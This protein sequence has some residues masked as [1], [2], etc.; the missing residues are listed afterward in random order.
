M[1]NCKYEICEERRYSEGDVFYMSYGIRYVDPCGNII[2]QVSDIS[3]DSIFTEKLCKLLND[4][5]VSVIH[6]TDIIAD[7]I[8]EIF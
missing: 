5:N 7:A 1:T 6:M 3:S 2:A 4:N 8:V